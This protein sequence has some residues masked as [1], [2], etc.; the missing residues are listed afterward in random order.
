[1]MSVSPR[2]LPVKETIYLNH[3]RKVMARS[4]KRSVEQAALSQLNRE[5]DVTALQDFRRQAEGD[6]GSVFSLN[7]LLMAAVARTLLRY[8]WPRWPGCNRVSPS[9]KRGLWPNL[10][11][12]LATPEE[13]KER[14][15]DGT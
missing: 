14:E 1:M 9:T 4:M 13:E 2:G 11:Q 5:I 12:A 3:L 6:G 10:Q 15:Y 8:P 7:T